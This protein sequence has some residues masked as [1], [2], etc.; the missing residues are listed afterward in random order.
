VFH[1]CATLTLASFVALGV[2]SFWVREEM[3]RRFLIAAVA[4]AMVFSGF[5]GGTNTAVAVSPDIVISQ[6]YGGGG[7]GGATL[8]NDFI[9]LFNRGI[10]AV[11]V[12][13]WSVQ[14]ASSAGSTWQVT[15]L[16]GWIGP[17]RYYLVQEAQGAGGSTSLPTPHASGNI[18]MSATSGKVALSNANATLTGT[19][20][21]ATIVD[22]VGYGTTANCFETAPTATLSNTTAA[23]RK[24]AGA[25][26]TDNN[27]AD[28]TISAPT[29]RA[30][31]DYQISVSAT[32]PAGA[33][34]PL[35]TNVGITFSEPATV[36]GT[37]FT[38]SCPASG[39]HTATVSGGP[40][41]FTLDPD[42]DFA[43][44]ETCT[45]TV[46][47]AQV[48][49]QDPDD[50]PDQLAANFV[51]TF[52]TLSPPPKIREIQ[53]A[54]HIS[55]KN[56]QAVGG[57][58]GLV[59]A[60]G[61]NGFWMQ[62]PAPDT[63]DA[64]SE[65]IFVFTSSAPATVSVGD[66]VTVSGS[67]Q[68]FRPGGATNA[69][70]TTTELVSPTITVESHGN[71]LPA[72]I[73][74]GVDRVPP[75]TVIEDDTSGSVETSGVFDP[76]SDGIDFWESL[77]GMRLQL[78]DAQAVGPRN[79][80]GE[81]A[82][83]TTGAG[84]RTTR[85]GIV[86]RASDFNPERVIIDDLLMSTPFTNTGDTISGA[87]IG[88]L[89][90]DF[91]NFKL[92]ATSVGT[93]TSGGIAREATAASSPGQLAMAT[94]NVENL[95][96]A[97]GPGQF[98]ALASIIVNNLRSPDLLALEEIQ[99]NNGAVNDSI[100]DSSATLTMLRDAV[101]AAGG[102]SYAWRVINPVDDQDGGE[103][104]GNIR[105]GFFFRTDRG[106]SFV[107]RPGGN[108]TS[109]TGVIA[110]PDGPQLTASPGRIDPTNTAFNT[111]RKPLVG[112]FL[113][114]THRLFVVANHFNSKGGDQ[115]LFGRFQ[116]P[117]RSTEVQRKQQAQI[118]AG[119]VSQ[120]LDVDDDALVA[121][122]GDLNDF[123]FSE[124][125]TILE[126]AGLTTLIE[127]LPQSERY[128]YVFDGNSQTLDHMQVSSGLLASLIQFDSVHVNSE[129]ADQISD[130]D[131]QAAR[132]GLT[133]V[134]TDSLCSLVESMVAKEGIASAL[135]EKLE[136]AAAS[137]ARGNANAKAGQIGAF[138][139]QINAQRGKSISDVNATR[140]ID[141]AEA[142]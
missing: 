44:N 20:P 78:N 54:A 86:I 35:N 85:G 93:V 45:V 68:E 75:G 24:T 139:N 38:I 48:A 127:T 106:L 89:D 129:F 119:F 103:P 58:A 27:S 7:N 110:G 115:P 102:P 98:A 8:R 50:P 138:I 56:G 82:V 73:V 40:T 134:T 84:I 67:V 124:A 97:D 62:D 135:C 1:V 34:V 63:N 122:I 80:F 107:D 25:Q 70:L 105:Q 31:A 28:F 113:Y 23:I 112:E 41:S 2:S 131:P 59:T 79:S 16:V 53:G 36:S 52:T 13:G 4:C 15:S 39:A 121:V 108:S 104:G 65:G 30:T 109:S 55:P 126:D 17:G 141:L 6:I 10:G 130:H 33:N 43:A 136:A 61:A 99:D 96:P 12:T 77:E 95:D 90:Y 49:D 37:W 140:L 71:P 128:S 29:P 117:T 133:A 66:A 19:C 120:I 88:V 3:S 111:S 14:Y 91:G 46:L 76:A 9:E 69:N 94:F 118:V 125:L 11:N 123:E 64:T 42:T 100:V 21:S 74:I 114:D 132:F 72:T 26:D 22:F 18:A 116:P 57:V 137:E 47:A 32:S 142:L 81:I 83:V 101:I 87:T 60:K 92:L 51:F 5:P